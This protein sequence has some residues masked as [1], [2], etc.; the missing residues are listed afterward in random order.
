MAQRSQSRAASSMSKVQLGRSPSEPLDALGD[1]RMGGEQ[2]REA[3]PAEQRRNDEEVRV[4]WRSLHWDALRTGIELF[5]RASQ[6]IGITGELCA[7]GVGLVFTRPGYGELDQGSRDGSEDQHQQRNE[8]PATST[9][10]VVAAS[11]A[12]EK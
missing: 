9:V 8:A 3:D 7:G 1:R 2:V 4:R 10:A 6:S 5:Q 11:H 12:P